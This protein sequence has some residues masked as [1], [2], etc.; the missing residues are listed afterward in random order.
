MRRTTHPRPSLTHAVNLARYIKGRSLIELISDDMP[1]EGLGSPHPDPLPAPVSIIGENFTNFT[2][3]NIPR[4]PSGSRVSFELKSK[5]CSL[6]L[7]GIRHIRSQY[8]AEIIRGN[9]RA[10]G[11]ASA[12]PPPDPLPAPIKLRRCNVPRGAY[13]PPVP[14]RLAG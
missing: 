7:F 11:G 4:T 14:L 2:S 8:K 10:G 1:A 12:A 5:S 3:I 13:P 9:C 6:Q